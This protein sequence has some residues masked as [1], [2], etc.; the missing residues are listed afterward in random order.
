MKAV[1][2]SHPIVNGI[3]WLVG[4]DADTYYV[5]D[6]TGRLCLHKECTKVRRAVLFIPFLLP[7]R[8]LAQHYAEEVA[9]EKAERSARIQ[10]LQKESEAIAREYGE[11]PHYSGI[12]AT[13]R[14]PNGLILDRYI[15]RDNFDVEIAAR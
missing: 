9:A 11:T 4:E 2:Y 3:G 7:I 15:F 5:F 8:W 6:F 10:Q 12:D 1:Q 13:W 14:L